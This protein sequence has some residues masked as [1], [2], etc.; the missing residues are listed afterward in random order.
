MIALGIDT[1]N[2]TTSVAWIDG[3]KGENCGRLLTVKSG[4]LGILKEIQGNQ[5]IEGATKDILAALG[6]DV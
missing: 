3:Q 1:S 4:E 6:A 2:Y 5:P